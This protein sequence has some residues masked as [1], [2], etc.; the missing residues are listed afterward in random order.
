MPLFVVWFL[1]SD[2]GYLAEE[3]DIQKATRRVDNQLGDES[4][5]I[6]LLAP[7]AVEHL[8]ADESKI[9]EASAVLPYSHQGG[10]AF[11]GVLRGAD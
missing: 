10:V 8:D 6:D 2:V 3:L 1:V 4:D 5:Q 11:V 9:V 7:R